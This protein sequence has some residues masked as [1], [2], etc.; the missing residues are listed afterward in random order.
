MDVN[1]VEEMKA[2][3]IKTAGDNVKANIVGEISRKEVYAYDDLL[4]KFLDTSPDIIAMSQVCDDGWVVTTI[5]YRD[6]V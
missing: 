4:Q 5:I 6:V 1:V 3:V 2:R